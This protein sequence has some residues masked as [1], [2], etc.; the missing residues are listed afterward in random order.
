MKMSEL[1]ELTTSE[2]NERLETLTKNYEQ[3]KI[4]H[5]VSSLESPAKLRQMRRTI[6]RIKTVLVM[7]QSENQ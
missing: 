5:A 3:D 6:A 4:N 7:R 1:K 2:L